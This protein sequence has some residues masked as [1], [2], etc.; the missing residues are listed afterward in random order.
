MKRGR[1]GLSMD[2]AILRSAIAIAMSLFVFLVC[3]A[4]SIALLMYGRCVGIWVR[5]WWLQNKIW[6]CRCPRL[7]WWLLIYSFVIPLF[8]LHSQT[9]KW[10][11]G[12]TIC[13]SLMLLNLTEIICTH[14]TF[15]QFCNV[16][17]S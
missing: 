9:K 17:I 11:H 14:F 8:W 3:K 2:E 10:R 6:I 7:V 4:L 1:I 5:F 12:P 16:H 13:I 15:V